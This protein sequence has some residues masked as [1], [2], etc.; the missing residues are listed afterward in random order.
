[1]KGL[2][3]VKFV[4][5]KGMFECKISKGAVVDA[6]EFQHTVVGVESAVEWGGTYS[7]LRRASTEAG[8]L[9]ESSTWMLN[10]SMVTAGLGVKRRTMSDV[11]T[12]KNERGAVTRRFED[13]REREGEG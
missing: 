7:E 10:P 8:M 6:W 2:A 3:G 13:Y 11:L 12:S 1:M 4:I 5:Q 9:G